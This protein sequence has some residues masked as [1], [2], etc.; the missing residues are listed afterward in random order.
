MN[1]DRS[2]IEIMNKNETKITQLKKAKKRQGVNP[3]E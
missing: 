1:Y 2:E 3:N